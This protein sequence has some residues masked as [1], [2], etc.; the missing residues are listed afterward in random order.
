MPDSQRRAILLREWQ[1]LS[2]HEIADELQLSQSAVETLIFRARRTL[3]SNL[4]VEPE[5]PSNVSRMRRVLDAGGLLAML[6]G[7]F[8][9]GAAVKVATVAVA[10]SGTV[11]LATAPPT[12]VAKPASHKQPVTSVAQAAPSTPVVFERAHPLPAVVDTADA[13]PAAAP[14]AKSTPAVE[15]PPA[16]AAQAPVARPEQQK[17]K[18]KP[19]ATPP[20]QAKKQQPAA[21][22]NGNAG[23]ERQEKAKSAKVVP[24]PAPP[25]PSLPE[26]AAPVAP[27]AAESNAQGGNDE[28][29]NGPKK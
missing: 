10:A 7:L 15:V 18:A 14:P 26:Q 23:K 24:N 16:A 2:Y 8:E 17:A 4:E 21:Q 27:H 1:G 13:K 29:A 12:P 11:V 5:R 6:K 3:A 19:K 20:G 22:A 28:K 9:G 25:A